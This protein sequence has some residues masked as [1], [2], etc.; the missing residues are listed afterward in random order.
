MDALAKRN[1]WGSKTVS[2]PPPYGPPRQPPGHPP[3]R[4]V[5]HW[6]KLLLGIVVSIVV[7]CCGVPVAIVGYDL[8]DNGPQVGE[9][10]ASAEKDLL[11]HADYVECDS[12]EAK[13]VV[14]IRKVGRT[15]FCP[16]RDGVVKMSSAPPSKRKGRSNTTHDPRDGWTV[17]LEPK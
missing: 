1:K 11:G 8:L 6:V 9:C 4:P 3:R 5:P 12:S 17:C 10:L 7:L 2:Y 16:E 15:S 13:Y 14:I